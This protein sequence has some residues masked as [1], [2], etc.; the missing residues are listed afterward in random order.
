MFDFCSLI[1][2]STATA[3]T[4]VATAAASSHQL[5]TNSQDTGV[6]I[7]KPG[8]GVHFESPA[9]AYGLGL[10]TRPVTAWGTYKRVGRGDSQVCRMHQQFTRFTPS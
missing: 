7:Y 2:C 3:A 9:Y 1:D 6:R 4:T 10:M 8:V 5:A